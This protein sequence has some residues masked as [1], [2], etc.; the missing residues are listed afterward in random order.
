MRSAINGATTMKHTL[1]EDIRAASA[2]GFEGIEIWWDKVEPYLKG[3]QADE[4]KDELEKWK[5]VPAG[6]CPFLVS[7]FRDT[8]K[9]RETYKK[10]LDVAEIIGCGLLTVCPDFRPINMSVREG[11]KQHGEEFAWYAERAQEKKVKIAIEPIGGH[12]MISGPTE[13]LELISLAGAPENVGIVF[14]TFHYM[15]SGVSREE[16]LKIPADRLYMVHLNDCGKGMAEELQ[17][18][19][20]CY[21]FEG[22]MDLK[23]IAQI[24][25]DI[26][27]TGFCSVEVFRPAYWEQELKVINEKAFCSIKTFL[28]D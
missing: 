22:C 19:D 16:M 7:P 10:A 8:V 11:M 21:P 26:G 24:L 20:R 2:A 3:H 4:L 15:K 1:E 18:K 12:S 5:I 25:K 13:A 17:D 27:Y 14:D 9:L 23:G 6:I 28:E